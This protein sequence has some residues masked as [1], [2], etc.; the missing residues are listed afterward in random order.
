MSGFQK[1]LG[2]SFLVISLSV[3]YYFVIFIPKKESAKIELQKQEQLKKEQKEQEVVEKGT[4]TKQ[5]LESCL[6]EANISSS[7][8]WNSECKIKGLLSQ[9]C[10][11]FLDKG[12]EVYYDENISSDEIIKKKKECNCLL[13]KY[14]A[15]RVD[16]HNKDLKDECFKKYPQ[17]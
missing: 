6:K 7:N 9:S 5:L 10:I 13:P 11:D 1:L 3:A 2:V 16:Q 12:I 4:E 17:K 14:N 8:F 15:D